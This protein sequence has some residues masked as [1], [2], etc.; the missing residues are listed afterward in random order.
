MGNAQSR[1]GRAAS[2]GPR[3]HGGSR[4]RNRSQH[5]VI[6]Q[7]LLHRDPAVAVRHGDGRARVADRRAR[8]RQ[9]QIR[10]EQPGAVGDRNVLADPAV[11]LREFLNHP[12]H[13]RWGSTSWPARRARQ[14]EFAAHSTL[15]QNVVYPLVD[16]KPSC[17]TTAAN[18][19]DGWKR[20]LRPDLHAG[21]LPSGAVSSPTE[22][23]KSGNADATIEPF[24]V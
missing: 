5:P 17:A 7:P 21:G 8:R 4:R 15:Q 10:R 19:R 16:P 11:M 3:A 12:G 23:G 6:R 1:P 14:H 9:L 20:D 22:T 18:G 2:S 24:P 13:R